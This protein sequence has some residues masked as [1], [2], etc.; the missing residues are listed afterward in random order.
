MI[1]NV[2][3]VDLELCRIMKGIKKKNEDI[4]IIVNEIYDIR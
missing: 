1:K 2:C 4:V 3:N